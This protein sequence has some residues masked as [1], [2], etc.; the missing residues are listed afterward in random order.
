MQGHQATSHRGNL[1]RRVYLWFL[2]LFRNGDALGD[3]QLADQ[4][5]S[6]VRHMVVVAPLSHP[7]RPLPRSFVVRTWIPEPKQGCGHDAVATQIFDE[8]GLS[9]HDDRNIGNIFR[10]VKAEDLEDYAMG[11]CGEDIRMAKKDERKPLNVEYGHR[12]RRIRLAEGFP[13]ISSFVEEM[14]V[15]KDDQ[16]FKRYESRYS[17]W[18]S[19]DVGTPVWFVSELRKRYGVTHDYVFEGDMSALP[20]DLRRRIIAMERKERGT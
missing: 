8:L 9:C 4:W 20:R 13:H 14:F 16:A 10:T 2:K 18:E 19:G 12:L 5:A 11:I 6:P 17:K 15:S 1:S 3:R 7:V